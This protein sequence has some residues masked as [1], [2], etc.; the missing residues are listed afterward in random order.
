MKLNNVI[1]DYEL[2]FKLIDEAG[3]KTTS[4]IRIGD[5]YEM[6]RNS[7]SVIRQYK[8]LNILKC[9]RNGVQLVIEH[10][11]KRPLRRTL[12][13]KTAMSNSSVKYMNNM[14]TNINT[15]Y[16]KKIDHAQFAIVAS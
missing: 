7:G 14:F 9:N 1:L 5:V 3:T 6:S 2:N 12:P 4:P 16:C 13:D 8:I 15:D 11:S 10:W